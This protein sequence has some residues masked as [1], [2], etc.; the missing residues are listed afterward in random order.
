[1]LVKTARR[2]FDITELRCDCEKTIGALT[3]TVQASFVV[4]IIAG[5]G[6]H[7]VV[8]ERMARTLK[9]RYRCHELAIPFGMIHALIAW[10]VT[11]SMHSA[12]LQS[13]T[14]S[15]DKVS[16]YEQFSGF[17]LDAKRDPRAGFG[18]YAVATNVMK[19]NF[20]GPRA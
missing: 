7:V 15:F 3:L 1:M 16:P 14:S 6:Q 10:Y 5:P 17:E 19:N 8:V 9:G 2:S 18:D 4:V 11:I 12:N 13:I 20:M